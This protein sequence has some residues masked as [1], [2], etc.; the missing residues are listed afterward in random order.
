MK[1]KLPPPIPSMTFPYREKWEF[2]RPLW[3]TRNKR[4]QVTVKGWEGEMEGERGQMEEEEEE[5]KEEEVEE[6]KNKE[7]KYS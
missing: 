6:D 5:G 2:E 1:E 4:L 7:E 3:L